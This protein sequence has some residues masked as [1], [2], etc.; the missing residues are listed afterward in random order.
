MD[1]YI[2][3][4]LNLLVRW[5][6]VIAGI[7][8]IGQTYL[9]NWMERRLTPPDN[10]EAKSNISGELWMVHGGGFYLVEKQKFPEIMPHTLHWFKWEAALTWISGILLLTIV[11]YLGGAQLEFDSEISEAAGVGI[12]IGTLL[13][14]WLVYDLLMWRSPLGVHELSAGV[15]LTCLTVGLAYGLT[16]VLSPRAAYM[17]IGALFG[18]IMVANVWLRILPAQRAMIQATRAGERPDRSLAA[19]AA[20]CSKQNTYMSFPLILIMISNHFP[21]ATYGSEHSWMILGLLMIVGFGAAKIM[22]G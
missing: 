8:W 21:T 19:R 3:E 12:G 13:L 9:F 22:R 6:H 18:T 16:C 7:T 17:H 14:G 2:S 1:P 5:F 4:W 15:I 11:Y 10:A 20:L